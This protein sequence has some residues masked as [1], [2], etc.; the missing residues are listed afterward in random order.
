MYIL[1]KIFLIDEDNSFLYYM[2]TIL[3]NPKA[4]LSLFSI[5]QYLKDETA[6]LHRY[7]EKQLSSVLF[8]H[9]LDPKTY[10]AILL[11]MKCSYEL[12]EKTLRHYSVTQQLLTNRSKLLWLHNDIEYLKTKVQLSSSMI[13]STISPTIRNSAEAMG[14]LYVMEGAT[15]GGSHIQRALKKYDWLSHCAG[16]E[17]FF[18][19]GDKR[20]QKWQDFLIALNHFYDATP[21]SQDEI[22]H[23]AKQAFEIMSDA[24]EETSNA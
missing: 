16:L 3:E 22:L 20:Q 8:T 9:H 23:G 19:Y 13:E 12:M 21:Y 2:N 4:E 6:E 14:M 18:S 7:V 10:L 17:F 15:L 1:F 5:H 11:S 24:L